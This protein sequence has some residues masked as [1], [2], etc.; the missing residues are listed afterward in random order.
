ME[1]LLERLGEIQG[2]PLG[3]RFPKKLFAPANPEVPILDDYKAVPSKK[4]WENFPK[5]RNWRSGTPFKIDVA[6]LEKWVNQAGATEELVTLFEQVKEDVVNGADLK[7]DSEYVSSRSKNAPSAYKDG[8][9][10]TDEVA[11]GL[12]KKIFVGPFS[13]D[14]VPKNITVNSLQT[15][16]KPN[17]KVSIIL[18]QSSPKGAGVNAFIKKD[19]YPCEMG[20]MQEILWALNFCGRGAR[21]AKCD[22]NAAYK[23]IAVAQNQLRY[24]WFGWLGMFFVELCLIFGC[25]SSVGLNDRLAQLIWLIVSALLSYP[26]NLLIQ[27]L[28]DL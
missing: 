28:D 10:V 19:H 27:R 3:P 9:Y 22:W 21:F 11:S 12:K 13:K 20:G 6:K 4:F 14:E 15:A 18:N 17:G 5:H 16:P 7:V 1:H 26:G 8:K 2:T 24:Q 25:I 23:H